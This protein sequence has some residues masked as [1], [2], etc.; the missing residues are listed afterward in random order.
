V[1]AILFISTLVIAILVCGCDPVGLR[2]VQLQLRAPKAENSS[3]ITVDSRDTQEALQ[4]LDAVV[5]R[6]S[7]HLTDTDRGYVRVYSLARPSVTVDGRV[8]TRSI[9]CRVRLTSTG[10]VVTF[11]EF[12][13]LATSPEAESLFADTRDAFIKRY[14]KKNVWSHRFGNA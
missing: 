6:H 10:L 3:T 2:R 12:G 4:I 8:Y 1:R 7:F 9:P 14:G 5:V 13:F 11:G